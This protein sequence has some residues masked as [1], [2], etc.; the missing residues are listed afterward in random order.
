MDATCRI[1][2]CARAVFVKSRGV[3]RRCYYR[4][5]DAGEI[6]PRSRLPLAER[7]RSRTERVGECL[8]WQGAVTSSGY[9]ILSDGGALTTAHRA[10]YELANGPIPDGMHVDH[11]C[12]NRRCVAPEHLRLAT[13][14]QNVENHSGAQSNSAT[15]VRGVSWSK[16]KR[17]YRAKVVSAGTVVFDKFF[18]SIEDAGAAVVDARSRHHTF[19]DA[20][21]AP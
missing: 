10:A 3:C 16:Q 7:L 4:M 5:L 2:G 17:R 20:D 9:G 1:A 12:H 18:D 13:P 15:G 19:N 14:R 8:E 21:R 6:V 11:I